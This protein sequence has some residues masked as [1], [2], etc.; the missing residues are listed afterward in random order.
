MVETFAN[1]DRCDRTHQLLEILFPDETPC[2]TAGCE[3]EVFRLTGNLDEN[4]QPCHQLYAFVCG[5]VKWT[6]QG[7]NTLAEVHATNLARLNDTLHSVATK[8]CATIQ[9][10]TMPPTFCELSTLYTSCHALYSVEKDLHDTMY[11]YLT[12]VGVNV[13]AWLIHANSTNKLLEKIV[14]QSLK[15]DVPSVLWLR[16]NPDSGLLSVEPARPLFSGPVLRECAEHEDQEQLM[17]KVVGAIDEVTQNVDELAHDLGH[18]HTELSAKFVPRKE[19]VIMKARMSRTCRA[20]SATLSTLLYAEVELCKEAAMQ[21]AF[22]FL[23]AS[24]LRMWLRIFT[25]HLPHRSAARRLRPDSLALFKH[26]H[27]L[28][29]VT[30]AAFSHPSMGSVVSLGNLFALSTLLQPIF[31]WE[32]QRHLVVEEQ[33]ERLEAVRN[34][35]KIVREKIA[36]INARHT[37]PSQPPPKLEVTDASIAEVVCHELRQV[38]ASAE[39]RS[40]VP[41]QPPAYSYADAIRHPLS[42]ELSYQPNAYS[43]ADAVRHLLSV[44]VPQYYQPPPIAA[45]TQRDSVG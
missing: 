34:C 1:V 16:L 44:L 43:Y 19:T 27:L 23:N 4:E 10:I 36:K 42:T 38:I 35:A 8:K 24:Q 5:G 13:S 29:N 18:L 32:Y 21:E 6:P 17:Q 40:E 41:Y 9:A 39:A 2:D 28:H 22:Y 14:E 33:D 26:P 11:A 30:N 25:R 37:L 7:G 31:E 3:Q 12:D 45:W 15:F 20:A